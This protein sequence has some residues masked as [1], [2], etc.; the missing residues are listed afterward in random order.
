MQYSRLI[1]GFFYIMMRFQQMHQWRAASL[2]CL[3]PN[4]GV[5]EALR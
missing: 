4:S 2:L 3:V 1:F 5:V